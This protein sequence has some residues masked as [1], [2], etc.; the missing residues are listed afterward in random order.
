MF[1]QALGGRLE[2]DHIDS[3]FKP[4]ILGSAKPIFVDFT[5]EPCHPFLVVNSRWRQHAQEFRVGETSNH[6]MVAGFGNQP[7]HLVLKKGKIDDHAGLLAVMVKR[8]SMGQACRFNDVSVPMKVAAF[9]A[10]C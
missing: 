4:R 8:S 2:R 10:M 3:G 5:P 1:G 9:G 7:N 6:P